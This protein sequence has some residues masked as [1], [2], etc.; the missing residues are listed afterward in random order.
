MLHDVDLSDKDTIAELQY[1]KLLRAKL[2]RE[3]ESINNAS[4]IGLQIVKLK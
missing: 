1:N 3:D 4:N 2:C